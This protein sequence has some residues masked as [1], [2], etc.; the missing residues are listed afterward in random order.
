MPPI[1]TKD[2]IGQTAL[3]TFVEL[4]PD[5]YSDHDAKRDIMDVSFHAS[6]HAAGIGEE[7]RKSKP[8][9]KLFDEIA[10]FSMWFFTLL[11]KLEGQLGQARNGESPRHSVIRIGHTYS[12]LVWNKYPNLCPVCYW[13][14]THGDRTKEDAS[15]IRSACDCLLYDV[16]TRDQGQKRTHV[17]A[18]RDY[19]RD[20]VGEKPGSVDDW[21]RMFGRIFEA[22]LR[23]LDMSDIA[24]HLLEE[25]GEVSDAMVRMYTYDKEDYRPG[26]VRWR[27]IWVE[28]ELADVSSWL[29]ALVEKTN[30]IREIAEE[31]EQWRLKE[32]ADDT[33]KRPRLYL[34]SIVWKKYGS[35]A[36]KSLFCPY[37]SG[38]A[39][40]CTCEI[41]FVPED[42]KL[43]DA[44]A[45][46]NQPATRA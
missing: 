12:D 3:D 25:L 37:G 31:Y 28:E 10:D 45:N 15:T 1:L 20:H 38:Q 26:E 5:I 8:G 2:T 13:R 32:G 14:R 42:I 46:Y 43:E 35:D 23:H 18:Q 4:I 7:V 34:S 22:N 21:Q 24:F 44:I 11:G 6:H 40:K 17:E 27:Q 41:L 30:W 19:A 16:E 39:Q 9:G 33:P 29:F 36:L